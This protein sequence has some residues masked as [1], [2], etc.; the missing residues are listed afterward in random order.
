MTKRKKEPPPVRQMINVVALHLGDAID[1]QTRARGHDEPG[2]NEYLDSIIARIK[3]IHDELVER[4]ARLEREERDEQAEGKA[5]TGTSV[6]VRNSVLTLH[7]DHD[8]PWALRYPDKAFQPISLDDV[9]RHYPELYGEAERLVKEGAK[10]GP[11]SFLWDPPAK[12]ET[13]P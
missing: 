9:R 6:I 2:E 13:K 11:R 1:W 4:E 12:M 5:R 3:P 10:E 7:M 8:G